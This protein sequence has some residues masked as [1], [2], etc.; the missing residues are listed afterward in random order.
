MQ[1]LKEEQRLFERVV[2]TDLLQNKIKNMWPFKK[3]TKKKTLVTKVKPFVTSKTT[4]PMRYANNDTDII[5]DIIVP[6]VIIG[7]VLSEDR[8]P[9]PTYEEPTRTTPAYEP[10]SYDYGSSSSYDS[11]DCGGCD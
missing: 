7:S 9:E 1:N 8:V 11:S 2:Y 5:E 10:L 4:P 6:A 3:K